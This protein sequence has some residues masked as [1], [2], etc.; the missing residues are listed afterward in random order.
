MF[1]R[2]VRKL[3]RRPQHQSNQQPSTPILKSPR[4][5]QIMREA[6]RIVARVH[7]TLREAVR[8]GVSTW[9]LDQIAVD[10]LQRY[11]ATS[12]FLGAYPATCRCRRMSAHLGAPSR[13]L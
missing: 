13:A 1:K 7:A 4:E 9:E 12:A 10:V 6:G 8:P 3:L 5:I 2:G 11:G